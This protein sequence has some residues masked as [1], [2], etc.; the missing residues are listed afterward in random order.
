MTSIEECS[1]YGDVPSVIRKRQIEQYKLRFPN[2]P[3]EISYHLSCYK[4]TTHKKTL[5]TLTKKH[6]QRQSNAGVPDNE[7]QTSEGPRH[8]TRSLTVLLAPNRV[9]QIQS[10]KTEKMTALCIAWK[11]MSVSSTV[12][13]TT[14][15]K[16][17]VTLCCAVD[18][19]DTT[20][21]DVT[22]HKECWT[23]NVSILLR[24]EETLNLKR[25][26]KVAEISAKIEYSNIINHFLG[27]VEV[28]VLSIALYILAEEKIIH[29]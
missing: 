26:E 18:N 9:I 23:N 14:S 24:K 7:P 8:F 5:D 13:I 1:A 17:R 12:E 21:L 27:Q 15:E 11:K 28:A 19:R 29:K 25:F 4:N 22:Y 2:L 3:S 10:T 6:F 16:L 20:A